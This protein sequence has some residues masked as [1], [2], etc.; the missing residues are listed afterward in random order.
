MAGRVR[1]ANSI[2]ADQAAAMIRVSRFR[3]RSAATFA[4]KLRQELGWGSLSRQA[5]YDWEV[6]RTRVP[7]V[8]ILAAARVINVSVD[9]LFVIADRFRS[10]RTEASSATEIPGIRPVRG[11]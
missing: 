2:Y 4:A 8:A 6:G 7:A 3:T 10:P 9:E 1:T 11:S 5:I